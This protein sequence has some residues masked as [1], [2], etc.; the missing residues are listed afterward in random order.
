[1]WESFEGPFFR[2]R[3]YEVMTFERILDVVKHSA[4]LGGWGVGDGQGARVYFF[5][6]V[7]ILNCSP[8][9]PF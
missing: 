4:T 6:D 3:A 8:L 5:R 7:M 9:L 2:G 1:M